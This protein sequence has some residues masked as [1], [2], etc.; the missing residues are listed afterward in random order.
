MKS[1]TGILTALVLLFSVPGCANTD[2]QTPEPLNASEQYYNYI[3]PSFPQY[4]R[5]TRKWLTG[6]RNFIS[7]DRNKEI[8]MNMPFALSPG[9]PSDKAILLVHGLGDS[10]FS[11]SDLGPTLA[12]QGFHVQS[13][14]LP[15]HGSKPEDLRL[16]AYADWQMIVDHYANLLK[17]QYA[18]VWLGGFST[19]AN[20]VT[21]H[22]IEQGGVE[23]LLLF[24]PG[25]VSQAPILEKFA[26]LAA[27]FHD[28]YA[29]EE[30]NMARYTSA[31]IEGAIT[32]SER[33][34]RVRELLREGVSAKAIIAVS[35]ADSIVDPEAVYELYRK[36]FRNPHNRFVWYG[37]RAFADRSVESLTMK[38][39]TSRVSTGSHMSPLFAPLNPYYGQKGARRMCMNSFDKEATRRCESGEDVWFAAWGYE[40]EGKI[41]ARLTWNPY[42]ARLADSIRRLTASHSENRGISRLAR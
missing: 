20:L 22:T 32:Y 25:F 33:A 11:F 36:H 26:P 29:A 10:P 6:N 4:L 41:H 35:E 42:Y 16:P 19:G 5:A 30:R 39:A 8:S 24:S 3:Q 27:V 40:E 18:E 9:V 38:V 15:G 13:L 17:Q 1:L 37:E 7:S 28:G 12:K 31:P 34:G 2:R 21:I 23:G 14:L